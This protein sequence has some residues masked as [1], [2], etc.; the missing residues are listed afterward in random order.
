MMREYL[1]LGTPSNTPLASVK[2]LVLSEHLY[3][4]AMLAVAPVVTR[5]I[6]EHANDMKTARELAKAIYEGYDFKED[7]LD[8]QKE[9]PKY[10]HKPLAKLIASGLKTPALRAAYLQYLNNAG[11]KASKADMAKLL[12]VAFYERNRYLA[13]RIAQT[14]LHRIHSDTRASEI[15]ADDQV[16]WVQVRMSQTHPK[17]DICD[18]HSK[19]NAYGKGA[20]IY[21]KGKAPKPPYHPFCR[22]KLSPVITIDPPKTPPVENKSAS[23][24]FISSLPTSQAVAILGSREKLAQFLRD[25]DLSVLGIVDQNKPKGYETRYVGDVGVAS[26]LTSQLDESVDGKSLTKIQNYHQA[27][28]YG[29]VILDRLKSNGVDFD[30]GQFDVKKINSYEADQ[31][32]SV[33]LWREK[34][35]EMLHDEVGTKGIM[36]N[37]EFGSG[38]KKIGLRAMQKLPDSWTEAADS[39]GKLVI[40]KT[41]A[42]GFAW[43]ADK[44]YDRGVNFG[45]GHKVTEPIKKGFGYIITDASSTVEH[46]LVH[47]VQSSLPELDGI[48]QQLHKDRTKDDKLERLIDITGNRGFK[49]DEV[50]RKDGYYNSYM[51]REY[52]NGEAK[53]VMTMAL[54]PILGGLSKADLKTNEDLSDFWRTNV[55]LIKFANVDR[56]LF[57]VSIGLLFGWKK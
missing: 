6:N 3:N 30:F 9:L 26:S 48:F 49:S 53:E 33:A 36:N 57:E 31:I 39:V 56:E 37:V 5:I 28:E 44:D 38:A 43:T 41:T 10:L 34:L 47:R 14:E 51:G 13:N 20:G 4:N 18:Y 11:D 27:A 25:K 17:Y 40:K 7:P 12:Q 22:C 24:A 42:R 46:E 52:G 2:G 8:V 50:A 21:P 45:G 16:H 32:N 35:L 29:R 55:N 54:E 19:L 15:M 1:S 23:R